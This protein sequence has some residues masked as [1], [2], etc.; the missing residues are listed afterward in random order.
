MKR[1]RTPATAWPAVADLMTVLA[2]IG[3]SAAAVVG[4]LP[5][6]DP[7]RPIM[8]L[9]RQLEERDSTIDALRERLN[10]TE[11]GFK[12][13]WR[14]GAGDRGYLFTYDVTFANG[15][16]SVSRHDHFH[17]GVEAGGPIPEGVVAVLRDVPQGRVGRVGL[18]RFGQRVMDATRDAYPSG[19]KLAVTVNQEAT[20]PVVSA[21]VRAGFYPVYR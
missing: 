16:Y 7:D 19:C 12:P 1:S 18:A 3:L 14:S 10:T 17:R 11:I 9:R 15:F 5:G 20:G 21:L 6:T 8:E 13:C 2:V 4:S